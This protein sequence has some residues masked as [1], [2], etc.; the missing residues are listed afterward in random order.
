MIHFDEVSLRVCSV[1][2][3]QIWYSITPVTID[4]DRTSYRMEN[5][6]HQLLVVNRAK[7]RM[8]KFRKKVANGD[9]S[10]AENFY[11][12]CVFGLKV[13]CVSP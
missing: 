13:I 2:L 7:E 3:L 12:C 8:N 9:I 1:S 11:E 6:V 5:V 10:S 4:V